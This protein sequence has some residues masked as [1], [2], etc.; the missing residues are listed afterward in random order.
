MD[1]R[2][3]RWIRET[4]IFRKESRRRS[5]A[6]GLAAA[7]RRSFGSKSRFRAPAHWRGYGRKRL[8]PS[9]CTGVIGTGRMKWRAS[10]RPT[11]WRAEDRT[12]W[13]PCSRCYAVV[14]VPRIR[15]RDTSAACASTEHAPP[16]RPGG[17]SVAT[18]SC[19][20]GSSSARGARKASSRASG[21]V[22]PTP[23]TP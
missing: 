2:A 18:G 3:G 1:G 11:C 7:R 16:T 13:S 4:T 20:R 14:W 8:L 10:A 9:R 19:C 22:H 6:R 21:C 15:R 5:T 12:A 23:S 17:T